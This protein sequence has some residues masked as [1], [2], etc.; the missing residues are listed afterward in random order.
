MLGCWLLGWAGG[1]GLW[2]GSGGWRVGWLGGGLGAGGCAG[3]RSGLGGLGQ[4]LALG[5]NQWAAGPARLGL[6][7]R[8]WGWA[9]RLDWVAGPGVE[10]KIGLFENGK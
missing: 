10:R 9:G 1:A 6:A 2:G 5:L 4:A 8:G 3:I 7:G